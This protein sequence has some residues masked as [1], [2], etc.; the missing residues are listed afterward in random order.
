MQPYIM[1]CRIQAALQCSSPEPP[2]KKELPI[3]TEPPIRKSR[4]MPHKVP[5]PIVNPEPTNVDTSTDRESFTTDAKSSPDRDTEYG[6]L[7]DAPPVE[8]CID[9]TWTY[10]DIGAKEASRFDSNFISNSN[11]DLLL[12]SKG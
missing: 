9:Q 2:I 10:D 4:S 12:T 11:V 5:P 8:D 7:T 6:D 3:Q 1:Q